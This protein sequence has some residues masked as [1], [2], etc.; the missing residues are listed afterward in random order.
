MG[1]HAFDEHQADVGFSESH[2][3]AEEGGGVVSGDGNEFFVSVALVAGE[4]GKD[5]GGFAIPLVGCDFSSPNV[6][7]EGFGPDF[8][9]GTFFGVAF[10]DAED[11][12]G[13]VFGLV[14]VTVVPCLEFGH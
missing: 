3:I 2:A 7:G 6:F 1:D 13:D 8:K 10:E 4:H 11:L 5:A 9:R 14:P 12:G